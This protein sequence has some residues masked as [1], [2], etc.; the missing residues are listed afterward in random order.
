MF[1]YFYQVIF[2][3]TESKF[4]SE[5]VESPTALNGVMAI[6]LTSNI[7]GVSRDKFVEV[8][9]LEPVANVKVKDLQQVRK[10]YPRGAP[11]S[12]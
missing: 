3:D 5:F 12:E 1:E 2:E 8:W 4:N 10:I 9:E 6:A 7:T 11:F